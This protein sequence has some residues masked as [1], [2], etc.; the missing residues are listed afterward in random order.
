MGILMVVSMSVRF[1]GVLS[2]QRV[3]PWS[4]RWF[5]LPALETSKA[6]PIGSRHSHAVQVCIGV[7][8]DAGI[9]LC[10]RLPVSRGGG[11]RSVICGD[12]F[13]PSMYP[14]PESNDAT[15][16]FTTKFL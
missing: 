9:R 10:K 7:L 2:T 6:Q 15:L 4:R 12:H 14:Y 3:M 16:T 13:G 11:S 8:P 5:S 1:E